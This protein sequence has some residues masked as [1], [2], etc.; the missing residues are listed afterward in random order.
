[1]I[2]ILTEDGKK[3]MIV[4]HKIIS[5]EEIDQHKCLIV[6]DGN[7]EYKALVDYEYLQG[8]IF[9]YYG[10]RREETDIFDPEQVV[11]DQE[12]AETYSFQE[13]QLNKK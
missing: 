4:I 9:N 8:V 6:A 10:V 5:F 13:Q 7:V 2:E 1:M 3:L 11:T 12:M